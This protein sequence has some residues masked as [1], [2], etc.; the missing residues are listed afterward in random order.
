MRK[1]PFTQE[2]NVN[3][4]AILKATGVA[5]AS[6]AVFPGIGS[7][8]RGRDNGRGPPHLEPDLET[9]VFCG[10]TQVCVCR[11]FSTSGEVIIDGA[12]NQPIDWYS[13]L[14]VDEG[15]ILAVDDGRN[16]WCNPNTACA[17]FDREDCTHIG[18]APQFGARCGEAYMREC[19]ERQPPDS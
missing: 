13:C 14:E 17:D 18:T 6:G 3:R 1:T 11:I 5:A 2:G 19:M 10:C 15:K 9:V 7:A 8:K 12:D 16:L 4:R